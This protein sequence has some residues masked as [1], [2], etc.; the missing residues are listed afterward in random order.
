MVFE[1]GVDCNSTVSIYRPTAND[2]NQSTLAQ[3]A[4]HV[5]LKREPLNIYN[6]KKWLQDKSHQQLG[7]NANEVVTVLC[8]YLDMNYV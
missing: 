6:L 1:L 3:I 8:K 5:A 2:I 7:D 4:K